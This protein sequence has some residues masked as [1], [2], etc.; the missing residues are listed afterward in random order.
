MEQ[1]LSPRIV[2][3]SFFPAPFYTVSLDYIEKFLHL[4]DERKKFDLTMYFA[5]K[6]K[7][8]KDNP[9][10]I[11]CQF[12]CKTEK[13]VGLA[14]FKHVSCHKLKNLKSKIIITY[15]MMY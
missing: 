7:A 6:R 13:T 3:S 5:T 4:D 11:V 1:L 9:I 15:A 8:R 10:S 2:S 14:K 12:H